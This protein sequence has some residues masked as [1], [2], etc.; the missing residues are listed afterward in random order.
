MQRMVCK[1]R[2][3]KRGNEKKETQN[4]EWDRICLREKSKWNLETDK[5]GKNSIITK[6]VKKKK[7]R[8]RRLIPLGGHISLID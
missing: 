8:K 1:W 3:K 6:K 5:Q 4:N 2:R 7:K